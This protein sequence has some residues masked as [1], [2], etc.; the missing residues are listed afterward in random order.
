M[1]SWG[2]LFLGVIELCSVVQAAFLIGVIVAGRRLADRVD[3]LA[4]RLDRDIKPALADVSRV[5]RAAAEIAE[6]GAL[7]ARRIDLLLA[8]TAEKVEE[9]TSV[10]Q[11]L[12]VRPLKPVSDL[13]ALI[14]GLQ[15]GVQVYQQLGGRAPAT[16]TSARR[17]RRT[18]EDD[19]HLFI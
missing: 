18:H 19:E 6:L 12:V 7:Q 2:V 14:K 4:S 17:S 11:R 16:H 15:R 13:V 9:T 8:D 1:E 5:S 10:I 3:A